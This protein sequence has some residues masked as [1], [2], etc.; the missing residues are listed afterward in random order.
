[1]ES[2]LIYPAV[3]IIYVVCA[4][5]GQNALPEK[6][7]SNASLVYDVLSTVAQYSLHQVAVSIDHLDS[8]CTATPHRIYSS[9]ELPQPSSLYV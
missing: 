9:R 8:E 7:K 3:L 6:G 4:Q 2:G 1:M 5:M